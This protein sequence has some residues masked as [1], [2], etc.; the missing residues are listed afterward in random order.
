VSE[1]DF[2]VPEGL[3]DP[4]RPSGG[5]R[6]DRRVA[7][8]LSAL[9]WVVREHPVS[10]SWPTPGPEARASLAAVVESLPDGGVVM[11]DGLLASYLP[12]LLVRHAHRLRLVVVMH[13]PLGERSEEEAVLTAG[14]AVVTTSRWTRRWLLD[15][16]SLPSAAVHAAPPGVDPAEPS[17]GTGTGGALLCVAVVTPEKGHDVLLAA[18]S[19]LTDLP[20][21][22]SCVGSLDRDPDFVDRLMRRAK[23]DGVLDRVRF[24]GP[25]VG[26]DLEVEY[27]AADALVLASQAETYGMVVAEALSHALPVLG[28]SVGGMPEALGR[29]GDGTAPGLLVAP[30]DPG[31]LAAAL[32]RWLTEADLRDRLRRSARDRRQELVT[33]RSTAEQVAAVLEDVGR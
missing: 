8:G 21:E 23:E 6:Y 14:R 7:E 5:N 15:H 31:A 20:W 9:G 33:W 26:P 30:R 28:T 1:V 13:L 29:A 12:D 27:A 19:T 22:L 24:T 17:P 2:V 25:L 4:A 16:Y 18:L 11:V 10:G 32:R 3:D